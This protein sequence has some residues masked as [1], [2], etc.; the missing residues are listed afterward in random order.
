MKTTKLDFPVMSSWM[1]NNG[2]RLD[3]N[4]YLS[5]AFEA[6]V[7]LEKLSVIKEPLHHLTNGHNGGI[8]NSPQFVRNYVDDPKHGVPFLRGSSMLLADLSNLDFLRKKDAVSSKLNYL[9]IEEGMTLISCSGT[10]GRMVYA[11]SDMQ[12]M[13]SSQ[14]IL[15][16]VP[17]PN[18][19]WPGY[20]YAYLS[21]SFGVPIIISGTYGAII[22]HIEP[23]HI[24]DLP[25]PRL[26]DKLEREVH[27]R[28]Q[29]ASDKRTKAI[30]Q[31]KYAVDVFYEIF[32]L[33]RSIEKGKP[34]NF[35]TYSVS[36]SSLYRLDA[37]HYC[38]NFLFA[39][40]ELKH[41]SNTSKQIGD[42]AKIFTP[43]I[44]KRI[45]VDE[46]SYGYPYF[47]GSELFQ[48]SPEHRGY[49]SKKAPNI[50]DYLIKKNWLLLQDAG[51]VGG[52][53][54]RMVR[55]APYADNSAVSNH[56]MR[57]V[58]KNSEDAAYLFAVLSS[59]HGYRAIVRHAF[60][61]SIPQLEPSHIKTIFIPWD[62]DEVRKQIA[63]I[64]I[65]AWNLFD[66]AD[67]EEQSAI[68]M[69]NEAIEG[70]V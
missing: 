12:G 27:E 23:H 20:L 19:I 36:S 66:Q 70:A 6:K 15:K 14:D 13:W 43:N 30:F 2:R 57:I 33:N 24:A 32:K 49:L 17:D 39:A 64:V 29:S 68:A 4:P 22:Q 63:A 52:L 28:I 40:D 16:V 11:R 35:T 44:F 47:S 41:C 37:F 31:Q 54:G 1:E 46:P 10:V 61:S 53:V 67:I 51:Q 58:A 8:Y 18:K 69:V 60:G 3:C 48:I 26:G 34:E 7:I 38:P 50:T 55:V 42:I 62:D 25:V 45:Y 21:S 56:L 65:E 9:R 59:P 5:G